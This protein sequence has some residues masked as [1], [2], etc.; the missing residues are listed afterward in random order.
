M[1]VYRPLSGRRTL[2]ACGS[3]PRDAGRDL[4]E[5]AQLP[6]RATTQD[7]SLRSHMESWFI[8]DFRYAAGGDRM[9]RLFP[10]LL[11]CCMVGAL[12]AQQAPQS[13]EALFFGK[14]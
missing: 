5:L 3:T 14:A 10:L 9:I 1:P 12:L 8:L 7:W 13:G 2:Q 11:S 6:C 4:R